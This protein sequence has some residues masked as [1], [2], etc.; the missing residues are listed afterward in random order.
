MTAFLGVGGGF[1]IVPVLIYGARLSLRDAIGSSLGVIALS[2]VSGVIGYA[3]QGVVDPAP[4]VPLAGGAI[5]GALA[6]SA[7]SGRV[8]EKP[9]RHGFGGLAFAVGIWMLVEAITA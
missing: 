7:V 1:L 4:L 6:G 3:W 8:P 9:L 5:C 2:C